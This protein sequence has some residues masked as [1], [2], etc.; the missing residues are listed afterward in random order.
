MAPVAKYCRSFFMV[1]EHTI[2]SGHLASFWIK[3]TQDVGKQSGLLFLY[4][5]NKL[6]CSYNYFYLAHEEDIPNENYD[7]IGLYPV[8]FNAFFD[9]ILCLHKGD[10]G[11]EGPQPDR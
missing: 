7:K 3:Q 10:R 4:Q 9:D 1:C 11:M 6:I 5:S 8:H 2:T